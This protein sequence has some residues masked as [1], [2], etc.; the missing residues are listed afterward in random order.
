ARYALEMMRRGA[1][2]SHCDW[3]I[4]WADEGIGNQLPHLD[5]ARRLSAL[6]C[7]RARLRFE[8]GQRAEAIVDILAAMA[9]G[10]HASRD[11]SLPA[12]LTGYAIER[13]MSETLARDLPKLDA[14][15]L[16]NLKKRLDALPA[17][18]SLGAGVREEQILETGWFV[19]QVKE[20]ADK[21][22]VLAF[23]N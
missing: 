18:G 16:K 13:S 1:A 3:A 11:G 9:M 5:G 21:A 6:A 20:A 19:R 23:L 22:S 12:I 7:L 10:R 8:E 2:L 15:T 14:R 17:G 4:G